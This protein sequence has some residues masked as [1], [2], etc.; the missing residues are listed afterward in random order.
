MSVFER[1]AFSSMFRREDF[2][3]TGRRMKLRVSGCAVSARV[4]SV[5]QQFPVFLF[6]DGTC[7]RE[8]CSRFCLERRIWSCE[9]VRMRGG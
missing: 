4:V 6:S 5:L 9:D 3:Q 8:A 1:S 2:I 7:G